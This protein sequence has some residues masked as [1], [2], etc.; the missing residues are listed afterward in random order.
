[1]IGACCISCRHFLLL[2]HYSSTT[3]SRVITTTNTTHYIVIVKPR[4]I[5]DTIQP[6]PILRPDLE[7][8]ADKI[9]TRV[10]RLSAEVEAGHDNLLVLLEGYVAL[11]HVVEE[12]AQ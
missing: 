2:H 12:D 5:E 9:A 6:D 1:M 3:T 10:G 7:T 8:R 4:V 11:D